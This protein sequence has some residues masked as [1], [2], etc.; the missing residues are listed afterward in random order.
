MKML[1]IAVLSDLHI[2]N[3]ARAKDLCPYE[4]NNVVDS[5]Y[6]GK[7]IDFIKK[8]KIRA[9]YLII[10][11]DI[12]HEGQ[13]DEFILASKLIIQIADTLKVH[14]K[15]IFIVPGNHDV[16]W[17]IIK[18][19]PQDKSG[20]RIKQRYDPIKYEE[21]IFSKIFTQKKSLLLE[22]PYFTIWDSTKILVIGYNSSW[23]DDSDVRVHYGLF[24]E[25]TQGKLEKC[26]IEISKL[27]EK[28]KI[29]I[30]HHH[31]VQYSNPLPNEPDFSTMT[32]AENLLNVLKSYKF[33]ML[34]HGHKH[35]PKFHTYIIDSDFPIAVL[36]SGS[37]S[38]KLD[39]R[40]SGHV[41]NQFHMIEIHGR[42]KKELC[43]YGT[44]NSWTYLSGHG[45]RPSKVHNGIRHKNYFGK[46][47]SP[48]K[49]KQFLA[50][51]IKREL[52]AKD[53]VLWSVILTKLPE[54]KYLQQDLVISVLKEISNDL[55]FDLHDEQSENLII[56]KK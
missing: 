41:N 13:P 53:Y 43:I 12:S 48:N 11:G 3:G 56:L 21:C 42:D 49:L 31:P 55:E 22:E 30:V 54:L 16:D 40:W 8:N 35:S 1:N 26:L 20:L 2:G 9:N 14:K 51:T 29:F 4:N 33:D 52:E 37:F 7:F 19:Y 17:S 32:N 44:V 34:I 6:V 46:Y 27:E 38:Y 10:S 36:C 25:D 39:T 47:T 24:S 45:W 18:N 5:D 28:L 50:P 15:N 23:H